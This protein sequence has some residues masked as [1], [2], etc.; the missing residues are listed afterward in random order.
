MLFR[1]FLVVTIGGLQKHVGLASIAALSAVIIVALFGVV[2][3]HPMSKVP[4]NKMKYVVGCMIT[5]FGIF[6][7]GEGVGIEWPKADASLLAIIPSVF[8]LSWVFVLALK[9]RE[10]AN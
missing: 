4:E 7:F 10:M 1:S 3:R 2:L 5:S 9:S 8:V 6:W